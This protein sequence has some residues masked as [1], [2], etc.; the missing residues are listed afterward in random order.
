VIKPANSGPSLD[1]GGTTVVNRIVADSGYGEN[2]DDGMQQPKVV[3][4]SKDATTQEQ[5]ITEVGTERFSR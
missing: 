1:C 4:K 2:E 5:D 3:T